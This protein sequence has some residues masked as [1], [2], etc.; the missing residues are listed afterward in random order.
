MTAESITTKPSNG[1]RLMLKDKRGFQ[2]VALCTYEKESIIIN[3]IVL[4]HTYP[5]TDN[6]E[7]ATLKCSILPCSIDEA[8]EFVKFL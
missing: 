1:F 5:P 8:L 6:D 3:K 7:E 4:G 2:Y